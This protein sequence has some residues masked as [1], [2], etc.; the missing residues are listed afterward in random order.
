ME[1]NVMKKLNILQA[2]LAKTGAKLT[3]GVSA[4]AASGAAFATDHTAAITAAQTDA[5]TNVTA[6]VVGVIALA[7]VICGAGYVL[8]LLGR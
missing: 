8:R 4:V 6:A 2:K 5:S 3:A 1:I 7:A